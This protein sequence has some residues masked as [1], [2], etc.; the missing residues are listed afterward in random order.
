VIKLP[1]K[2]EYPIPKVWDGVFVRA[3][4]ERDIAPVLGIT[5]TPNKIMIFF[6]KE[7]SPSQKARLDDIMA[8]P[9]QPTR[10]EFGILDL[11]EVI[12]SE[13]G[14]KPVRVS[15]DEQ[16]D[17]VTI[18]FQEPLTSTQETKLKTILTTMRRLKRRR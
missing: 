17:H 9:P 2:Y 1:T 7:L 11:H 12:E 18:D 14:V 3:I 10:Y 6:E 16:T 8:N 4:I 15:V 5:E 13:L